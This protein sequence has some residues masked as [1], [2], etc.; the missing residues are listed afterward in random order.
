[1]MEKQLLAA[2]PDKL[3]SC[4]YPDLSGDYPAHA[5]RINGPGKSGVSPFRGNPLYPAIRSVRL[6]GAIQ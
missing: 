3:D 5:T 1:M 4:V 6:F 2:Q